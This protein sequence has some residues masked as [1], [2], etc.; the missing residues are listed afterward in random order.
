MSGDRI[1]ES[2]LV[3]PSLYLMTQNNGFIGIELNE[4]YFKIAKQRI[5]NEESQPTLF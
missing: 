4:E 1:A 3:L 5:E 2:E